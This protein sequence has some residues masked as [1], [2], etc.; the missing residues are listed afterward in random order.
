MENLKL[1]YRP[2]LDPEMTR[3]RL[4]D[5]LTSGPITDPDLERRIDR[6]EERFR[7]YLTTYPYGLWGPGLFITDEMRG[8]TELYL[9]LAEIKRIFNRFFSLSL[10]FSPFYAA[11]LIHDA[12]S[13]PDALERL[14]PLVRQANPARLLRRLM[15]DEEWRFRFMFTV[16]LPE[17]Y[18]GGFGRY[19]EQAIFLRRWLAANRQRFAG[20]VRCL[21]AACG[22]GEG[23]YEMVMHLMDNGFAVDTFQVHGST[24]EPL[25]L[26]AAAHGYFPHDPVREKAFCRRIQPLFACGAMDRLVFTL[27]DVTRFSPGEGEGYDIIMCNGLLGG[28][29]LHRGEELIKAVSGLGERLKPGGILLAADRFHGGWKKLVPN[30]RLR[31]MLVRSGLSLLPV[32]EG[33]GGMKEAPDSR[34]LPKIE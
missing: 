24:L 17:R 15:K 3:Q 19:P 20:P 33:V 2:T 32:G 11:S 31:E 4:L 29:F 16:F 22:S 12:V 23:T 9:P 8:M 5:L 25:E 26:F 6:L 18:G 7:V 28:P 13:W 10:N 14:Y 1:C 21:D 34:P 30:G 27:G